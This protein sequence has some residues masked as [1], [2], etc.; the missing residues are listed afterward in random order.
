MKTIVEIA[1]EEAEIAR[2]LTGAQT[3]EEAVLKAVRGFLRDHQE[4]HA[5]VECLYGSVPECMTQAELQRM[6]EAP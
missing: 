2:R 4:R 3:V 1:D 6:R 5:A